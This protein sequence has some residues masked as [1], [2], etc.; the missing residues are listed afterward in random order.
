[1]TSEMTLLKLPLK[2]MQHILEYCDLLSII[3]LQKTC[4]DL[5]NFI[6]DAKPEPYVHDLSMTLIADSIS[7]QMCLGDNPWLY[8][9]G[10]WL[11]IQ[12]T[13]NQD[14]CE[15]VWQKNTENKI[16][17]FENEDFI[18]IFC[19]DFKV[20]SDHRK[21][22]LEAFHLNTSGSDQDVEDRL[23]EHLENVL[24]R[25]KHPIQAKR[26]RMENNKNDHVYRILK[27]ME[28]KSLKKIEIMNSIHQIVQDFGLEMIM[29]LE[30]WQKAIE[31]IIENFRVTE[32]I[33]SFFH[34]KNVSIQSDTLSFE[35]IVELKQ[36]F[37]TTETMNHFEIYFNRFNDVAELT[38]EIGNPLL[39]SDPI[40]EKRS[41]IFEV[42]NSNE[43]ISVNL[44]RDFVNC[45]R[46]DSSES[47]EKTNPR[48]F[49]RIRNPYE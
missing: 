33:Q 7:F 46:F 21:S 47:A 5:R 45:F 32:P 27:F 38:Q 44:Y 2:L 39:H 13:K 15:V 37:L 43:F 18:D 8:P 4:V 14:E 29:Q 6:E 19:K 28:P 49:Q 40:G 22:V 41:W 35:A 24:G 17:S 30:Q 48:Y 42:P 23:I 26:F 10:D 9:V 16:I 1:M 12:Y 11:W 25:R 36:K 20:I 3:S 34:F 31:V